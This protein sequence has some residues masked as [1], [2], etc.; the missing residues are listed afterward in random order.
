M[1]NVEGRD[2]SCKGLRV[3][4]TATTTMAA[5]AASDTATWAAA[6]AA[7][8]ANIAAADATTA[9]TIAAGLP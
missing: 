9:A 4:N 3:C 1:G 5:P 7:A 6:A 8:S 2:E